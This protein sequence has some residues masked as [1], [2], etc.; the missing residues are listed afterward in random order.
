[1]YCCFSLRAAQVQRCQKDDVKPFN[2]TSDDSYSVSHKSDGTGG[3]DAGTIPG[4]D[5]ESGDSLTDE[6]N[7]SA[8]SIVKTIDTE[9]MSNEEIEKK[10]ESFT[11]VNK[12]DIY[13]V[14]IEGLWKIIMRIFRFLKFVNFP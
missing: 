9:G 7:N 4:S 5:D 14:I 11:I 8:E 13:V 12:C 6:E 2:V 3:S 1:M 10:I